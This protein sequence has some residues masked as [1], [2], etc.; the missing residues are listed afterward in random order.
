MSAFASL[1]S[2]LDRSFVRA[3]VVRVAAG[4]AFAPMLA[5]YVRLAEPTMN[6]VMFALVAFL[7]GIVIVCFGCKRR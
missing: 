4:A 7:I 5:L 2:K 6:H 3:L 1:R